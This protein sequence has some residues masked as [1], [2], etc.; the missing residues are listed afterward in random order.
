MILFTFSATILI[1]I[2]RDQ[3]HPYSTRLLPSPPGGAT[4]VVFPVSYVS[5]IVID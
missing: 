4:F 5:F 1:S 3:F 2:T